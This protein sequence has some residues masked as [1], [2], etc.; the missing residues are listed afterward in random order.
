M[1]IPI[2]IKKVATEEDKANSRQ[3]AKTL[4]N[5]VNTL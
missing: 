3:V 2:Y 4:Q 1:N 5:D